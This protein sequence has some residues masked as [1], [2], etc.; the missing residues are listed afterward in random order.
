MKSRNVTLIPKATG[1]TNA[2]KKT[3]AA[4]LQVS[5]LLL[6]KLNA[7]IYGLNGWTDFPH[8]KGSGNLTKMLKNKLHSKTS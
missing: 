5:H 4:T 1:S 7:D 2:G 3:L 8:K 6:Q